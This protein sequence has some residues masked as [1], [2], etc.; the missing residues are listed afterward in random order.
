MNAGVNGLDAEA[1]REREARDAAMVEAVRLRDA[2][3]AEAFAAL[4]ERAIIEPLVAQAALGRLAS[5]CTSQPSPSPSLSPTSPPLS[6]A[7]ASPTQRLTAL[8]G[9]APESSLKHSAEM[10]TGAHESRMLKTIT[11]IFAFTLAL[12]LTLTLAHILALTGLPGAPETTSR[13]D[14]TVDEKGIEKSL[15][16]NR[17]CVL[18]L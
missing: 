10:P 4:S 6:A 1:V 12:V 3:A 2:S 18:T 9:N 15:R 11:S 16:Q 14:Q 8:S 7:T 5:L 17:S 13:A